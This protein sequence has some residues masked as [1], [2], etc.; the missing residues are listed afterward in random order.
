MMRPRKA[1]VLLA[2]LYIGST[3]LSVTS[4]ISLVTAWQHW[5]WTLDTCISVDCGCILYG[6]N[7][8]RTFVGGD[9][10]LCQFGSYALIPGILIA[11]CLGGYHGYRCF[12]NKNFDNPRRMT[13]EAY[14]N[15]RC[16]KNY[17]FDFFL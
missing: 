14:S 3:L 16:L 17:P 10:R 9:V 12:I 11:L 1:E 6:I 8:F 15:D 5:T 4:I 2:T 7:A 13:R